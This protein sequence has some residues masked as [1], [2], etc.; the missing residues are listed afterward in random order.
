MNYSRYGRLTGSG[1]KAKQKLLEKRDTMLVW[2]NSNV[3]G[4]DS[5]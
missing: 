5:K 1:M 2:S 4:V 3:I